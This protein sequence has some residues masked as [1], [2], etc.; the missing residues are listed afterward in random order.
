MAEPQYEP[1]PRFRPCSAVINEEL[2]VWG[3]KLKATTSL[4]VY[5]PCLESWRELHTRGPPP[6]G[7]LEGVSAH[8]EHY[9]Y[10][11]GGWKAGNPPSGCLHR[12]DTKTSFWTQLAAHSADAPMKKSNSGMIMYE[13][14]VIVIGGLGIRNGPIQPGS[15]WNADDDE[16]PNTLG[17]TNEMHK[18]DLKEG[19]GIHFISLTFLGEEECG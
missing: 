14:S 6:P 5:H 1:D 3:G 13:N 8:S 15:E 16:D 12:L 2:C 7:L 4:Q 19:K 9:L 18:Y 11:Y 17:R 10:V